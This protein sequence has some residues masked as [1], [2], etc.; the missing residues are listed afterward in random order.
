MDVFKPP[1]PLLLGRRKHNALKLTA[2]E[3]R[4]CRGLGPLAPP[5]FQQGVNAFF[6]LRMRSLFLSGGAEAGCQ[7][8][9]AHAA[10]VTCSLGG[11]VRKNTSWWVLGYQFH[12]IMAPYV[13]EPWD[14]AWALRRLRFNHECF[15]Y[16]LF[17]EGLTVEKLRS[18]I[19]R[20]S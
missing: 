17:L 9:R 6:C 15:V 10:S 14:P 1:A 8:G 12:G 16:C 11:R 7:S 2:L 13:L 20:G 3:L 5:R 18:E 4:C 19:L